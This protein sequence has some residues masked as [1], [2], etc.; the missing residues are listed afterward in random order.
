VTPNSF[1]DQNWREV[2]RVKYFLL[3]E[4]DLN[5]LAWIYISLPS[6]KRKVTR[7]IGG[8]E[9]ISKKGGDGLR[10]GEFRSFQGGGRVTGSRY[11]EWNDHIGQKTLH[12]NQKTKELKERE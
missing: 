12:R 10:Y 8:G 1:R 6:K 9:K 5:E 2:A 11:W 4:K 7:R 3:K